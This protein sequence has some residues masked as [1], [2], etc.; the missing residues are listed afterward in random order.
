ME[1]STPLMLVIIGISSLAAQWLA[2]RLRIP[3]ILPLLLIGITLGPVTHV[4]APDALFG[5]LLFPL[6]SLSVAIILFE[7][8][9]LSLIH[10]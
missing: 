9:L 2:W 8:S 10:I 6:V 1:L 3:A 4:I 5:E 7:G